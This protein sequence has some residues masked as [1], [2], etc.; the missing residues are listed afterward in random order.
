MRAAFSYYIH[1]PS[2]ATAFPMGR[3]RL[4]RLGSSRVEGRPAR[5]SDRS[6]L[7]PRFGAPLTF[8]QAHRGFCSS[9]SACSATGGPSRPLLARP[10]PAMA[11][12]SC[13]DPPPPQA[14]EAPKA[15]PRPS[16]GRRSFRH[17][18]LAA[19]FEASSKAWLGLLRGPDPGERGERG[20]GGAVE[21]AAIRAHRWQGKSRRGMAAWPGRW[22]PRGRGL[23]ASAGEGPRLLPGPPPPGSPG[24]GRGREGPGAKK[25][26]PPSSLRSQPE[27]TWQFFSPRRE[28]HRKPAQTPPESYG[29][30]TARFRPG[31]GWPLQQH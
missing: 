31:A 14:A 29:S 23:L 7:S 27:L 20:A 30:P 25:A 3:V 6:F 17:A 13:S 8:V 15:Q 24:A 19:T 28:R 5:P 9:R 22:L 16:G 26:A 11:E 10:G 21:A 4:S 18:T 1:R 2:P 12:R